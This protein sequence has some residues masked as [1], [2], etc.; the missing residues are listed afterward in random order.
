MCCSLRGRRGIKMRGRGENASG[1]R[2]FDNKGRGRGE[3]NHRT[4]KKRQVNQTE[5]KIQTGTIEMGCM[6]LARKAK[7]KQ[8]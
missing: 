4:D 5:G 7:L 8:N 2:L 6:Y 3:T 1:Q